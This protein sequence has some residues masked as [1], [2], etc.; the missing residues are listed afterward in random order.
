MCREFLAFQDPD[1]VWLGS[2]SHADDLIVL[3][4]VVGIRIIRVSGRTDRVAQVLF[5]GL[6]SEQLRTAESI[7]SIP[8]NWGFM[9]G[10]AFQK[11]FMSYNWSSYCNTVWG[12]K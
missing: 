11:T 1:G 9:G 10:P 5:S 4:M 6:E 12:T 8:H 3:E 2:G 7:L